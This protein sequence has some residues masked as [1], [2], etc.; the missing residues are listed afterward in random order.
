MRSSR[1]GPESADDYLLVVH[2]ATLFVLLMI[3]G[4]VVVAQDDEGGRW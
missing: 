4:T 1:V 2:S 3:R